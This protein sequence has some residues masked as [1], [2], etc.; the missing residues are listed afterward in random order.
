MNRLKWLPF[1]PQSEL[2]KIVV[3]YSTESNLRKKEVLK[4]VYKDLTGEDIEHRLQIMND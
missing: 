4:R 1:V 2:R 3:G